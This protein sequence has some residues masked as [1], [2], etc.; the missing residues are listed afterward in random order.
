MLPKQVA[1]DWCEMSGAW[2]YGEDPD[3]DYLSS[4]GLGF[5]PNFLIGKVWLEK[6]IHVAWVSI[7]PDMVEIIRT[8]C[9]HFIWRW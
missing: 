3:E 7:V 1:V 9:S 2:H 5:R 8:H 4:V 6:R